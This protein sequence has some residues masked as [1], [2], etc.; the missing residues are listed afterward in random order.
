MKTV[1]QRIDDLLSQIR[2]L[3]R[4]DQFEKIELVKCQLYTFEKTRLPSGSGFDN[5]CHVS[6]SDSSEK[7]IHIQVDYHHMNEG[8][9]YDGWTRHLLIVRP[10]FTGFTITVKGIN[11]NDIKTHIADTFYD[12][13][14]RDY[15]A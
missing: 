15:N 14:S 8:G 4:F 5:G 12:V 3:E 2:V 1:I 10:T 9:M 7:A 11:K 13:L 6:I